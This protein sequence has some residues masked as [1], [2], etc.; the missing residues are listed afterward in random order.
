MTSERFAGLREQADELLPGTVEFR[1]QLHR[2][3]ELGLDLPETQAAVLDRL[4]GLGLDI[5]LGKRTTSV[6][7][8][9]DTGRPGNTVL[10]RGDMDALPMPEDTGLEFASEIDGVMHACGHDAHTAMLASAARVLTERSEDLSGQVVFMFQPGEEGYAGAEVMLKEGLLDGREVTRAFAIHQSP[11][12]RSGMIGTRPGT[13]LASADEF[14]MIVTG[15]GGHASM[16]HQCLDPVPVACEIVTAIQSMITRKVDVFDPAVVTVGRIAAGTTSNVIPEVAEVQG[17]IRAVSERTRTLVIDE[18]HRLATN[19]AAAHGASAAFEPE[20]Y[21]YP[22]TINDPDYAGAVRSIAAELVGEAAIEI[23]NPVMGAE[24][25]SYVLQKVPGAM[26]FL[27]TCPPDVSFTEA[28]PN[29]SNRMIIDEAAMAVGT[30]LYAA[31]ALD[32]CGRD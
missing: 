14:T 15:K 7:A 9:L 4:E 19:I 10:L 24:D 8:T 28:A 3:P 11:S 5:K 16:P 2:R 25:W 13:L 6:V 20:K 30:A 27:G 21:G 23:P 22:P 26:A 1:R 17:T 12:I 18:L 31:V 29:H 32:Q